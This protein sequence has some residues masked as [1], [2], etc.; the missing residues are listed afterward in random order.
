MNVKGIHLCHGFIIPMKDYI[1]QF[2]WLLILLSISNLVDK[3]ILNF[4]SG[5]K[6]HLYYRLK[7]V[8]F[9]ILDSS[10]NQAQ[11]V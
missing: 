2:I 7:Y 1:N 5:L 9:T 11:L 3:L 10:Y 8:E 6:E 4:K